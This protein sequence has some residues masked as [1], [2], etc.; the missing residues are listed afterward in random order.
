M[1]KYKLLINKNNDRYNVK[2]IEYYE[3][4]NIKIIFN[5]ML[6]NNEYLIKFIDYINNNKDK[7]YDFKNDI[8]DYIISFDAFILKKIY[9]KMLNM[10]INYNINI[11][12]FDKI[13]LTDYINLRKIYIGHISI[14]HALKIPYQDNRAEKL[15]NNY[16]VEFNKNYKCNKNGVIIIAPNCIYSNWYKNN[17]DTL[18]STSQIRKVINLIKEN[19][20]LEI[21]IRLHPKDILRH[22]D[23]KIERIFNVKINND[24][25]DVLSDRAYCI[26]CDRSSIGPKLYLKGNI[27]F[28]FQTNYEYS[29]IGNICLIEPKLLN[30]NNL[31]INKL[32]INK[33]YEYLKDISMISYTYDEINNGYLFNLLYPVLLKNKNKITKLNY[34]G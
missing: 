19:S 20:N 32:C 31:Y 25:L 6:S 18:G 9:K 7:K 2:I 33:R 3:K 29:I 21:E 24:E 16:K 10:D 23:K 30:P 8:Y 4:I 34:I 13:F 5:K 26:I 27:I 12:I 22:L 15:I 1:K 28:N 14:K 11:I 17:K